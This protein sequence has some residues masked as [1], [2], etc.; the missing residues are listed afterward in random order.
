VYYKKKTFNTSVAKVIAIK[1]V[2]K[3]MPITA[4]MLLLL[5]MAVMM[6]DSGMIERIAVSLASITGDKYPLIA[7]FIGL[8]GS[9]ITGS[10]TN[11]NIIFGSLQE[12]AAGAIAMSPVIICAAQSIGASVGTALGPT[13]V[14]LAASAA[15]IKNNESKLYMKIILPILIINALIGVANFLTLQF[16][17]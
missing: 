1:T 13:N 3:C 14:S 2:K 17:I 15:N 12:I 4:M 16:I 11:S 9:F 10:N 7:P 6:I 8:V 5:S